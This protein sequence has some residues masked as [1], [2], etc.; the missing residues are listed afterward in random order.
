MQI[1]GG[2][3]VAWLGTL[4]WPLF[5]IGAMMTIAPVFG[6][7]S[8]PVRIRVVL[9]LAI[10]MV[11]MPML[12]AVPQV[13]LFSADSLL[14]IVQQI[15]IGMMMGLAV[16]V[17]FNAVITGAQVIAMQMALGFSL[18][19]DPQNGTQVPVLSQLYV[20][21]VT[22]VYLAVDGHLILIDILVQ[23]FVTMPIAV[24]GLVPRDLLQVAHWGAQIFT[25]AVV[26]AL[27]AIASL[28][29]VNL[30]FGVMTRAAPQLNIFAV[31]FPIT[32]MLGFG[33]ILATLPSVAPQAMSLFDAAHEVIRQIGTR[34]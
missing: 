8:V 16:Q 10:T 23:S 31:G 21:L 30:A 33:V 29:V 6:A 26:I 15:L 11:T 34:G 5:R 2:E 17:V 12:P 1:T 14:I 22:L 7:Q 32:M 18:M 20:L 24:D 28:L 27:P 3:I 13:E 25:G 19:V 4:L 9:A